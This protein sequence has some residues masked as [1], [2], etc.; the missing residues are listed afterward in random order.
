MAQ[1]Q[2]PS[3]TTLLVPQHLGL[4]LDGNR[5]WA[6]EQG[7]PA[8]EGHKAG[9]AT[10]KTIAEAA[11]DRGVKYLT[12]YVFST[13]NWN[14]TEEE[15]GFLMDFLH[16]VVT[17]EIDE[18]HNKGIRIRFLGSESRVQPKILEAIRK[19]EAKTAA[20]TTGQLALCFNYG[21]QQEISEAVARMIS[22]GVKPEEVTPEKIASYLYAPDIPDIDMVIRTSG[23]QRLSNFML[24]RTA[25]SEL[26]FDNTKHWPDFS[27]A[28]LDLALA[29]YAR[30]DRRFGGNS[31]K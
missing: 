11:L 14:R 23:E 1:D 28:D 27:V 12:A 17:K 31:T 18:I 6:K 8:F 30:R 15:V 26:Y 25:Y 29:E 21:G 16:W 22:E 10:L 9:Y 24:W 2:Q 5:R 7:K 3:K 4:I 20:N 13:E 19:A